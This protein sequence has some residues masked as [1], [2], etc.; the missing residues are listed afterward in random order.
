MYRLR[1]TP[2]QLALFSSITR[3][4]ALKR[5]MIE[6]TTTLP[7]GLLVRAGG[8]TLRLGAH[9]GSGLVGTVHEARCLETGEDFALKRARASFSTFQEFFR[10]EA[11]AT[12]ALSGL[13]ALRPA[14]IAGRA[15]H[16]LLKELLRGDT[17][18]KLILQGSLTPEQ[19]ESLVRALREVATLH[20]RLGFLVDLS[21]KNLCWQ[22]G[23]VLVDA[24]PKTHVTDYGTL[25][26]EPDWERYVRYFERKGSLA[27]RGSAPSVLTRSARDAGIPNARCFAF[28]RDWWMWLPYDPGLEPERFFV[29]LDET[30]H[31]DEALFRVDLDRGPELV[32]GPGAEPRLV[33]N[34][35]LRAC[36][37]E[38]WK[39]QH[40][41]L[42]PLMGEPRPLPLARSRD[43]ISLAALATETEPY[44]MARALKRA[45][46]ER[47][48]LR[49]PTLPVR[50]YGH[51][52]DL[53]RAD[54]SHRLTDLLCH[55]PLR[56]SRTAL[57][58]LLA[59]H[60]HFTAAPPLSH[61]EGPFCE[62]LC[63]PA[64]DC[65]RAILFVPGFRASFEAEA[66]LVSAL[67]ARGVEGLFVLTHIGVRNR[68]GQAMVTV[69]RWESVL[70]WDAIDY[71]TEFLGAREV[72]LVSASHGAIAS[73]LVSELH[74]R[75]TALT[76][77]SCVLRPLDLITRLAEAKGE[78]PEHAL[79][80]LVE[81]HIPHP[82][83]LRAPTRSG[84]RVLSMYPR[85]D[86]ILA[87]C[88][89]LAAG[90]L[91]LYEGGHAATMRHDSSEK[92][93][94]Q[95]CIDAL[96]AFLGSGRS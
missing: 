86:R 33:E 75:V 70:L 36:A 4:D 93:V 26:A 58:E 65:R 69:G 39:Q 8:R 74:P 37:L 78:P 95:V 72:V 57:E 11:A 42:P 35:L 7:P 38:S 41:H 82:F 25:L 49:V 50:P 46:P 43:P 62:L 17:L 79:Q 63:L 21:P 30:Q 66:A 80:A 13:S 14:R 90:P 68:S 60:P 31:E 51:W 54:T 9:L 16:V 34:E 15:P 87:A 52:T 81:Q 45:I 56:N 84:L 47:E 83:Q 59:R 64:G 89:E 88:G 1:L 48:H 24:G 32:A 22:D 76:L 61:G 27:T 18:Q 2:G 96:H 67:L 77:D 5:A 73:V 29:T 44:G 94:P 6:A 3:S 55:E 85:Q 91:T 19:R 10:L 12:E 23:W 40:P 71:A 20:A 92:G 53:G 28:V